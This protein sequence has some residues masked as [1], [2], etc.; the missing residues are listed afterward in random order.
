VRR[1]G[2]CHCRWNVRRKERPN[3]RGDARTHERPDDRRDDASRARGRF[4][5]LFLFLFPY[6]IPTMN[7]HLTPREMCESLFVEMGL[8]GEALRL[9]WVAFDEYPEGTLAIALA[10]FEGMNPAG[11]FTFKLREG[12]HRQS[13]PGQRRTG[14]TMRRGTHGCSYV[15]DPKGIDMLPAGHEQ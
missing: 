8:R 14:W 12:E 9:G 3:E 13:V 6:P 2:R 1:N 11:L 7:D 10:A 5:F 15:R 4:L